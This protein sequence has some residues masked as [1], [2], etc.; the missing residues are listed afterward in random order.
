LQPVTLAQ[1]LDPVGGYLELILSRNQ[2]LLLTDGALY[3]DGKR[4]LPAATIAK[5]LGD[6][7]H[8]IRS[9]LVLGV[10]LGSIVRTLR[11]R[12]HHASYT[13]VEKHKTVLAWAMETLLADQDP[14]HPDE[15][16]PVCEDAEAFMATNQR[17]FDLV[18]IDIFK[19]RR[20]PAFATTPLFLRQCR[21]SVTDGGHV[22]LNYLVDGEQPWSD[23]RRAFLRIFPEAHIASHRDNRILISRPAGASATTQVRPT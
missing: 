8:A 16:E 5:H 3:S 11:S 15:L 17:R 19:G 4:Y 21:D 14:D 2:F 20:V 13:L 1:S 23:L 12:H 6:R 9:V 18:F 7:L 22:A 10:G